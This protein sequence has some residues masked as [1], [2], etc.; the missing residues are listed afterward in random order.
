MKKERNLIMPKKQIQRPATMPQKVPNIMHFPINSAKYLP[1]SN[2]QKMFLLTPDGK[3]VALSGGKSIG[4]QF[5]I[6]GLPL[7]KRKPVSIMVNNK[8]SVLKYYITL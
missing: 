7:N 6:T 4:S 5:V 3:T 1:I 2:N 8:K